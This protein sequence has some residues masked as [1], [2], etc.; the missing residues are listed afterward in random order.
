M[1]KV[2]KDN[3]EE[4]IFFLGAGA[5]IKAGLSDVVKLTNDFKLWLQSQDY[6]DELSTINQIIDI[7]LE[8]K[9]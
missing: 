9:Q 1:E 7:I 4:L 2:T 8:W 5:S 6:K 3:T